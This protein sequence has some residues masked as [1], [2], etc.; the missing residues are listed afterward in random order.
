[1]FH[2][3]QALV[4]AGV[5]GQAEVVVAYVLGVHPGAAQLAGLLQH[6]HLTDAGL[7]QQV[8]GGA[9]PRRARA[10]YAHAHAGIKTST[11]L[12]NAS[13]CSM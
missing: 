7:R 4:H 12:M 10:H 11:F 8:S 9:Q 13:S 1:M 2:K 6:I 3:P 5:Y